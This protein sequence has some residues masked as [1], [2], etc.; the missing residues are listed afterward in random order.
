MAYHR[1]VR[2]GDT[3]EIRSILHHNALDLITLL[4]LTLALLGDSKENLRSIATSGVAARK[5]RVGRASALATN[6]PGQC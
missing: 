2:R 5:A 3:R 1:F 4:Q 6:D